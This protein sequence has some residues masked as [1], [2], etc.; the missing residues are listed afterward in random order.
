MRGD[1]EHGNVEHG[2]D[3]AMR[4]RTYNGNDKNE[5]L[6]KK[7][8]D[9]AKATGESAK[10]MGREAAVDTAG[11]MPDT[12]KELLAQYEELLMQRDKLFKEA[13]SLMVAYKR[14]FGE[15]LLAN[16]ELKIECVREKKRISYCR[17]R[18]NRG[19]AVDVE[20]MDTEIEDEMT[21]YMFQLN[22]MAYEMEEAKK[23]KPVSEYLVSRAKKIY[24][25]LAKVLHPDINQRTLV[26]PELKELWNRIAE[27]Y[28]LSDVDELE[29]LSLM[30]RKTMSELGMETFVIAYIDIE[31]RIAHVE[32]HINE[33][34]ST[35]PYTYIEL[36]KDTKSIEE[37]KNRLQEEHD[38]YERYLRQLQ[39]T[40]EEMLADGGAKLQWT[41]D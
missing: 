31:Q 40:L 21:M 9:N 38:D 6:R 12:D 32:Q 20:R 29:D 15:M 36:L 41:L 33:I 22:E 39:T 5:E 18:M 13:G 14:E 34:V 7:A 27:A 8:D 4:K 24:R 25:R 3:K 37:H 35:E 10:M 16:F 11:S 19:L 23:A 2:G 28:R 17:R 30:V 1:N 26:D